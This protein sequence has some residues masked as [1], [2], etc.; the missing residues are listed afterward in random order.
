M[1]TTGN[2]KSN[3]KKSTSRVSSGGSNAASYD[4]YLYLL[5]FI[6]K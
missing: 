3:Y 1:D 2:E 4:Y 6:A 5:S